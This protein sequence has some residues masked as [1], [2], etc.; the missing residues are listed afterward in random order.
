MLKEKNKN[1]I[2]T[3]VAGMIGSQLANYF[4]KMNYKVY[5]IDCRKFITHSQIN[6]VAKKTCCLCSALA[7]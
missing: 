7:P 4:L 5:G 2:I 6:K 3:G 1:I